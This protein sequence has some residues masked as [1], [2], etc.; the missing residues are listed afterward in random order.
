[1]ILAAAW[2]FGVATKVLGLDRGVYVERVK[3]GRDID[4]RSRPGLLELGVVTWGLGHDGGRRSC[5]R[6]KACMRARPVCCARSS[7][8]DM[9]TTRAVCMRPGFWVCA[10][11]TQPS[12]VTVHYLGSLFGHCSWTLFKNTVHRVKKKYKNFKNFLGGD[13]IYEIFILNLL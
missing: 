13:L 12:F 11:Y 7:T 9:G 2:W 1:M 4:L 3:A 6:D 8:H 10:L 5:A